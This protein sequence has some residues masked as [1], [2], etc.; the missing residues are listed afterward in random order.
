[1]GKVWLVLMTIAIVAAKMPAVMAQWH[2]DRAGAIKTLQLLA[3]YLIYC[4]IGAGVAIW[5]ATHAPATLGERG[6]RATDVDGLRRRLRSLWGAH[7]G[8]SRAPLPG[9]PQLAH[10]IRAGR[11]HGARDLRD[12]PVGLSRH[13][14]VR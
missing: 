10:A 6:R 11:R 3:I 4:L 5:L 7:T 1:M 9:A 2:V 14:D 12:L 8:E 13:I